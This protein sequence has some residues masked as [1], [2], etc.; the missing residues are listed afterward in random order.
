ME[1]EMRRE[2]VSI[3]A[4]AALMLALPASGIATALG[5]VASAP[6]MSM[7]FSPGTM[8]VGASSTLTM[9]V[10][11]PDAID[12]S[13]VHFQATLH[14]G[15][16]SASTSKSACGG[17]LSV[18][19]QTVTLTG[20]Q[21]AASAKCSMKIT[22]K[23]ASSGSYTVSATPA[24]GTTT[25]SAAKASLRVLKGPVATINLSSP[26]LH[27]P[28][29]DGKAGGEKSS[30]TLTI[31]NP[32]DVAI[33][34]V[35]FDL[36]VPLHANVT[37]TAD[38]T[39]AGTA[40]GPNGQ[41]PNWNWGSSGVTVTISGITL[42]KQGSCTFFME[43]GAFQ[44]GNYTVTTSAITTQYGS[45]AAAS[46][47]FTVDGAAAS[48]NLV[49]STPKLSTTATPSSASS[50][51]AAAAPTSSGDSGIPMVAVGAGGVGALGLAGGL[52]LLWRRRRTPAAPV[53]A[54]QP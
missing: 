41:Y 54:Q 20:G 24:N 30:L 10:S 42:P 12:M 28:L 49:Y 39:C 36:A 18:S 9:T 7:S 52:A 16:T 48:L 1:G 27:A 46:A 22:V 4:S 8:Y 38:P 11:N 40:G 34:G 25:G 15:L 2:T 5:V 26:A 17:T 44:S 35:R 13:D 45:I 43:T 53:S 32:N 33:S 51:P 19:G 21:L 6:N 50:P 29:L 47:S 3:L 37:N 23:G 31:D 14:S